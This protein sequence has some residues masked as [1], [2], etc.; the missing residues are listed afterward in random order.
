MPGLLP[1]VMFVAPA[2]AAQVADSSHHSFMYHIAAD[3]EL[4]RAYPGAV[5][6]TGTS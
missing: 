6:A 5:V 3:P 2:P 4:A 1:L